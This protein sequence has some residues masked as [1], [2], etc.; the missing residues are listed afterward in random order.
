MTVRYV[1]LY[2]YINFGDKLQTS[3]DNKSLVYWG[4]DNTYPVGYMT[5][6]LPPSLEYAVNLKCTIPDSGSSMSQVAE[7]SVKED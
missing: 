5:D 4:P 2:T 7:S 6:V 3:L 1:I